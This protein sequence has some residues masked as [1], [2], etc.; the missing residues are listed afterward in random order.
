M[1]FPWLEEY[2]V[3]IDEDGED[4]RWGLAEQCEGEGEKIEARDA[5][6]GVPDEDNEGKYDAEGAED[7]SPLDDVVDRFGDG[8]ME[9]VPGYG[10]GGDEGVVPVWIYRVEDGGEEKLHR[11]QLQEEEDEGGEM[12]PEGVIAVSERI[13]D[14]QRRG[15]E[16]AVGAV[17][18]QD[19][20]GGGVGE[21]AGDVAKFANGRVVDYCVEIIEVEA[22]VEG[23]RICNRNGHHYCEEKKETVGGSQSVNPC[24]VYFQCIVE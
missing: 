17:G 13:V 1:F 9:S 18:G 11:S 21:E 20:E 22:I 23:I 10:D 8:G 14:C 6:T 12:K 5:K 2:E 4:E 24:L 7:V 15:D 3:E 16:G 19:A